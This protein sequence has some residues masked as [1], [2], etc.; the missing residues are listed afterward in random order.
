MILYP[1]KVEFGQEGP[2]ANAQIAQQLQA[3]PQLKTIRLSQQHEW[4]LGLYKDGIHP[5]PEGNEVVA[6]IVA[7]RLRAGH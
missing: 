6:R 4:H 3:Y 1:D 5:T 7:A 2:K